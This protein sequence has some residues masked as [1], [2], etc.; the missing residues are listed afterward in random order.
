MVSDR[1]DHAFERPPNLF[2]M[3]GALVSPLVRSPHPAAV[4]VLRDL[5][6]CYDVV[7][8]TS[9]DTD[10]PVPQSAGLDRLS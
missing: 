6:G 10:A 4:K 2:D 8:S 7:S 9:N 1:G 3:D 5:V